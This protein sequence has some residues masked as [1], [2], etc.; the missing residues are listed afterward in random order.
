MLKALIADDEPLARQLL[1]SQLSH[2]PQVSWVREAENGRQALEL[3]TYETPD[4]LLLDVRMPGLDG[5]EVARRLPPM[6]GRTTVFVTAHAEH[7]LEAFELEALDYLLKPPREEAVARIVERALRWKAA[8]THPDSEQWILARDGLDHCP[9][10]WADVEWMEAA[11][12]Y[13][14][15]CAQG[16]EFLVRSTLRRIAAAGAGNAF[17]QVHRRI[18]VRGEQIERWSVGARG[19]GQ[20]HLN[21]GAVLPLSRR[22]RRILDAWFA[23]CGRPSPG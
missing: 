16:Q 11:G 2:H 3:A 8:A 6:D 15:L 17:V 18:L 21:S 5:L 1:R 4:L 22:Y 12:N 19:D 7:A 20:I 13:V 9:L 23:K 14:K 10:R